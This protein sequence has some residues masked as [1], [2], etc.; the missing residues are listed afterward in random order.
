VDEAVMLY[1]LSAD[2]GEV[3]DVAAAH[4]AV[5]AK[6]IAVTP[7]APPP[8]RPL[9]TETLAETARRGARDTLISAALNPYG[10]TFLGP[11]DDITLRLRARTARAGDGAGAHAGP[12]VAERQRHPPGARPCPPHGLMRPPT[13]RNGSWGPK[14]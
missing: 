8:P 9:A 13:P 7:P 12:D 11:G 10:E 6:I 14:K 2:I 5:V 3:T 4:P 1:D